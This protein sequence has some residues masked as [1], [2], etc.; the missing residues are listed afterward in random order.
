MLRSGPSS[1]HP[2]YLESLIVVLISKREMRSRDAAVAVVVN[3]GVDVVVVVGV[4]VAVGKILT[5]SIF[6]K[7]LG[8]FSFQRFI[9]RIPC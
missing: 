3:A 4:V 6:F 2:S 5:I 8:S 7:L 1:P 9:Q